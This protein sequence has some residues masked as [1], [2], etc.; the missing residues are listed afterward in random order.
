M[1]SLAI[2]LCQ[3]RELALL[4]LIVRA[5]PEGRGAGPLSRVWLAFVWIVGPALAVKWGLH[6]GAAASWRGPWGSVADAPDPAT[7]A[8]WTA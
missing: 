1:G 3:I 4:A 8:A 2:C 7:F 5:A 6:P